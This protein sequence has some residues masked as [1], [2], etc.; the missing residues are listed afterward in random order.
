M[1]PKCIAK[2]DHCSTCLSDLARSRISI[3]CP[4]PR[5]KPI[6]HIILNCAR[7]RRRRRFIY[8]ISDKPRPKLRSACRRLP[9]SSRTFSPKAAS[10]RSSLSPRISLTLFVVFL[11]HSKIFYLRFYNTGVFGHVSLAPWPASAKWRIGNAELRRS[12]LRVDFTCTP[13][14]DCHRHPCRPDWCRHRCN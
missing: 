3:G 7:P 4:R 2:T 10:L 6:R 8:I 13:P 14:I 5:P 9:P 1:A 11:P 12:A